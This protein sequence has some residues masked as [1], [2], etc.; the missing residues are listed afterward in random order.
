MISSF[1]QSLDQVK[2]EE[3]NGEKLIQEEYEKK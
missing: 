3:N 2:E 1:K